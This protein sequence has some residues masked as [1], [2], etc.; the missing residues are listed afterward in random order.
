MAHRT[1]VLK[2][3]GAEVSWVRSVC[4]SALQ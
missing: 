4:Q 2:C 1:P 3:L